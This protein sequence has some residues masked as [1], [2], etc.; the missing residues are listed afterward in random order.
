MSI[1]Q[2]FSCKG[3]I[4]FMQ[5]YLYFFSGEMCP[6]LDRFHEI[7]Y[8]NNLQSTWHRDLW[9]ILQASCKVSPITETAI[10]LIL[11]LEK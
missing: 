6:D 3:F 8:D 11:S 9:M 4:F 5:I 2:T 1:M 10:S 7:H